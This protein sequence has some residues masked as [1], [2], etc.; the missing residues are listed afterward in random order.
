MTAHGA[1]RQTSIANA[2]RG[3]VNEID[4]LAARGRWREPDRR[5]ARELLRISAEGTTGPREIA[6]RFRAVARALG[7]ADRARTWQ[8]IRRVAA[9]G[10]RTQLDK[11]Y[12][13]VL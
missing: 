4:S 13:N 10:L 7:R 6:E 11:V 5:E 3:A 9:P 1:K 8:A 2:L 12:R